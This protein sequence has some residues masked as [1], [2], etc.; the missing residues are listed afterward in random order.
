MVRVSPAQTGY[1]AGE[2]SPRMTSRV[3]FNKY[4]L[5]AELI[6]NIIPLPQGGLARRPGTRFIKEVKASGNYT[7]LVPFVYSTI[8]AYAIEAGQNYFRFY[9]NQ[10]RM[11]VNDVTASITNGTFEANI[12][13]WTDLSTGAASILHGT[14]GSSSEGTF[15]AATKS[16]EAFGDLITDGLNIGMKFLN[17]SAGTVSS[18][19]IDVAAVTASF[20]AVA[21]IYEDNAGVPG[22]QNGG[23]SDAV[24]L[25]STGEKTFTWSASAPVLVAATNYW[26]VLTDS[27]G[28]GTGSIT[29]NTASDQGSEFESGRHDTI[30]SIDD[31]S[32]SFPSTD[33]WRIDINLDTASRGVLILRGAS[34][35][36]S[37]ASQE[38]TI[39]ENT[40]THVLGFE[41]LGVQ[42]DTVKLRIGTASGGT[43]VV[44]DRPVQPGFH[45]IAFTPGSSASVFI[46]FRNGDAKDVQVDTVS[47]LDDVPIEI[48][49]PWASTDLD[50]LHWAQSADE[51]F[52]FHPDY[53]PYKLQRRSHSDWALIKVNWQDGPYLDE[54][55]TTTTMTLSAATVGQGRTLTLSSAIG[56]NSQQGFLSTDVGR[57]VRFTNTGEPGWMIITAVASTLSATVDIFRAPGAATAVATWSLG[58]WS[59]TTGWPRS[60]AFFEQR[61]VAA[62]TTEQPQT[63]W[64]SQS[65]DLENMR[66]DSFVSSAI[67]VEDDD[68]IVYTIASEKVNAIQWLSPGDILVL[69]TTGGEWVARSSG[70]V[71][72]NTDIEVRRET[73]YGSSPVQPVRVGPAV[74]FIQT[75]ERE[76]REFVFEFSI[77]GFSAPDLTI[78]SNHISQSGFKALAFAQQPDSVL[79][80]LRRDGILAALTYKRD[81]QV[82]GWSRHILGGE[83]TSLT[84]NPVVESIIS[85]PGADGAG[86]FENSKGRDEVWLIVKRTINS[87]TVRYIEMFEQLFEGPIRE[88]YTT[89]ALYRAAVLKEQQ[90]AYYADSLV[91]VDSPATIVSIVVT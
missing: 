86:Q 61:I 29:L 88:D 41:I 47:I 32:G 8:Q 7:I 90:E 22:T 37:I 89:D 18:V 80:C 87:A 34:G 17:T 65:A 5:A 30:T 26:V 91:T 33:D 52:F 2:F 76:L 57:L 84:G 35:E 27:T 19:K 43:D 11:A 77:D 49:T 85:I 55:D 45:R 16:T 6:E 28:G 74:L 60:V 58:A 3:D 48:E 51:M 56:V 75:A 79:W 1:N 31:Q 14:I 64:M 9:R 21:A 70:A 24:T 10:A 53:T 23:D 39:T 81:N 25:S 71:I 73:A 15:L 44:N 82:A 4:L 50:E 54:N 20:D 78:L 40:T 83:F 38:V 66:P 69:G 36:T 68:A 42:T 67:V 62:A 63:F 46:Q 59:D 13:S 12:T 72:T